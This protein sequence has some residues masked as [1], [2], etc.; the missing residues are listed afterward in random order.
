MKTKKVN[1]LKNTI[2]KNELRNMS[3]NTDA[4]TFNA[5]LTEHVTN[6]DK[7]IRHWI[8]GSSHTPINALM[9]LANDTEAVIRGRIAGNPRTPKDTLAQLANDTDR[10]VRCCVVSNRNVPIDILKNL[11]NDVCNGVAAI[12]ENTRQDLLK[13]HITNLTGRDREHAKLLTPTFTGWPDELDDLILVL[14][15]NNNS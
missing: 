9:T 7:E 10:V 4:E 15:N 6:N 13:A 14:T 12:V 5:I 8:A 1:V 3:K 2:T 11:T